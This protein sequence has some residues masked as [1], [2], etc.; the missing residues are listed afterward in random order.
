MASVRFDSPEA[1]SA[2][3]ET[4]PA[5]DSASAARAADRQNRLTKP[6]G[7]LG[8]L[9]DLA[10]WFAG[11]SGQD[12]PDLRQIDLHVFAGNHGVV[13]HGV[14]PYPAD[15]TAQMVANF[16]KG[17]AAIN[18]LCDAYRL[19]LRIV[20]LYLARPTGDIASEPAMS[21]EDCLEAINAGAHEISDTADLVALGE[22][23]IGNTTIASALSARVL[24]GTGAD[25]AGPGAGL[26]DDGMALK[27]GVID[28]AL[29]LHAA[30]P[31]TPFDV[32]RCL[33]GREQAAIA[34]AVVAARMKRI[35][36]VLD[37]F[38]ATAAALPLLLANPDCLAHCYASHCSAEPGHGRLLAALNKQPLLDLGMRLGEGTGAA[39]AC[40]V[41]KGA[42]AMH[43]NMATFSEAQVADRILR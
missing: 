43:R 12:M 20:P 40:A 18:A 30:I 17:G 36:V 15:V 25:W 13:R 23:G 42:L 29:S 4:L 14:S 34:G 6:P 33:G 32:L 38:I 27:V 24:G 19:N 22:M 5:Y 7:S 26:C 9:E 8:Q 41:I 31:A 28:Q 16:Y 3:L 37:G 39:L 1:F 35:P 21:A 10:I 11:W 2:S